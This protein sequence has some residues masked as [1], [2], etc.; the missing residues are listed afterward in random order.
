MREGWEEIQKGSP[1]IQVSKGKEVE[2]NQELRDSGK[3]TKK[4]LV[5]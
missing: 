1:L 3:E 2:N 4:E 5:R